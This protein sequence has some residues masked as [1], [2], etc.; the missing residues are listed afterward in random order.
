MKVLSLFDGISCG[1]VAFER[2]GIPVERYVAYEI[3][4]KAISVSKKNYP[5]IMH[6]GDV[7][8]ANFSDYKGFDIVI[9]GSPC[10]GFSYIGKK[11][12]FADERSALFGEYVRALEI[13][14]PAWF[15]YENTPMKKECSD[16]IS[17]ALGVHPIRINSALV[18]AQ[19][20]VRD[21]W[22]NIPV[23]FLPCDRRIFL[24]DILE[25][26]TTKRAKSKTVR[27]G[28]VCSG[29]GDRHEWDMPN[30]DRVYTQT[31][32]ER[33]QTLP[34][35]Y[36][37]NLDYRSAAKAIGNGWTVDVIAYILSHIERKEM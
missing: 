12:D 32:L 19:N 17:R 18:S 4:E 26:G 16:V 13:V 29:W 27:V 8:N 23:V 7:R 11:L 37:D 14:R 21:Y 2:E 20:R 1:R 33:L 36:T 31:E 24:Q 5:D 10:Q 35:G 30:P 34:D 9:G 28:G 15:L 25:Y 3:D 22:T 6:M